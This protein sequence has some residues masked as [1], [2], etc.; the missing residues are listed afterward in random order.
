M[1]RV[2]ILYE[3]QN[4][5]TLGVVLYLSEL[6]QE[7]G[8]QVEIAKAE[9]FDSDRKDFDALII[10]SGIYSGIL[11]PKLLHKLRMMLPQLGDIPIWGFALSKRVLEQGGEVYAYKHY[12]PHHLFSKSNLQDFRFFARCQ[13]ALEGVSIKQQIAATKQCNPYSVNQNCEFEDWGAVK[14]YGMVIVKNLTADNI[15]SR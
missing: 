2:L 12:I 7:H 5:L 1:L 4:G 8:L 15:R 11:R 14:K 10:G 9:N 3:S 6:L 13:C